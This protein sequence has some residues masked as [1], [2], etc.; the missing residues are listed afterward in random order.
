[1]SIFDYTRADWNARKPYPRPHTYV[2]AAAKDTLTWHWAGNP[3]HLS[4]VSNHQSCLN[5]IKAWQNYHMDVKGWRDLG[6]HILICPHGYIIEGC[7]GLDTSA[8]HA[9]RENTRAYGVQFM[10]GTGEKTNALMRSA[11][12]R[13]EDFLDKHAGRSLIEKGHRDMRYSSTSCPGDEIEAMVKGGH[14]FG[15][16]A[17]PDP[18]PHP[19]DAKLEVDGQ[20]GPKTTARAQRVFKSGYVDGVVSRQ[21]LWTQ[22]HN[23]GL[24][25]SSWEYLPGTVSGSPLIEKVQKWCGVKDVDGVWGPDTCRKF[26]KHLDT[27]VDG[28]IWAHSPAVEEFQRWLNEQEI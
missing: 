3:T 9:Y 10:R 26:Q 25:A 21:T 28:E 8:A 4:E 22:R 16:G 1:M 23:P 27:P 12:D 14:P 13:V 11:A 6:Y 7:Q 19:A 5:L 17:K 15:S 18:K 24:L 2:G 20:W